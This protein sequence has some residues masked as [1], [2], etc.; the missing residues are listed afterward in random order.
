MNFA[1]RTE[2]NSCHGD[3]KEIGEM[4]YGDWICGLCGTENFYM[5]ERCVNCPGL[6]ADASYVN[7][8]RKQQVGDWECPKCG[9]L[10]F[11]KRRSCTAKDD[12]TGERC[13]LLR[14]A[15]E[16]FNVSLSHNKA[17]KEDGDWA[18]YRC[19]NVNFANKESCNRCYLPIEM[20]QDEMRYRDFEGEET[21]KYGDW[22]CPRC[23]HLNFQKRHK[24]SGMV[25]GMRCGLKRPEFEK[26]NSV[27]LNSAKMRSPGDWMCFRCG[28]ANFNMIDKCAKCL[29]SKEFCLDYEEFR[30]KED[31]G[32]SM[33]VIVSSDYI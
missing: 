19:G 10:N 20:A 32:S 5:D 7:E 2:C 27:M 26:Y 33:R 9:H 6:R 17:V 16:E 1:K 30:C 22:N 11:Q 4:G 15:F 24:C 23:M 28:Y 18:C 12:A 3:R 21:E 14:P 31:D 25:S 13:G 29:L 8:D